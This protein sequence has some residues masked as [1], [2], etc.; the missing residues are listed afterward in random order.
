MIPLR[1]ISGK[2]LL[3]KKEEKLMQLKQP[4]L[5]DFQLQYE[6]LLQQFKCFLVYLV[7]SRGYILFCGFLEK[8]DRIVVPAMAY[9]TAKDYH[10]KV[11]NCLTGEFESYSFC[12]N[13]ISKIVTTAK[14][15]ATFDYRATNFLAFFLD[16]KV[17][18][19]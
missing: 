12:I 14:V 6:L 2:M 9:N 13:S 19:N 8:N 17:Y 7:D 4:L 11:Q 5:Q 10:V 3:L 18:R 15:S 1:Q 16:K